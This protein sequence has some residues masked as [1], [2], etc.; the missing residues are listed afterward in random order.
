MGGGYHTG[1][2]VRD[3]ERDRHGGVRYGMY[4]GSCCFASLPNTTN[5][6]TR[7]TTMC[8]SSSR[9]HGSVVETG[10]N[11]HHKLRCVVVVL[12]HKKSLYIYEYNTNLRRENRKKNQNE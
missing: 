7:T 1:W 10:Y 6:D 9:Y 11:T 3:I 5:S 4:R 12:T 8:E 2:Q